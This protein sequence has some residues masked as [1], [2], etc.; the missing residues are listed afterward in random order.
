[1]Q[2][3]HKRATRIAAGARCLLCR[4][5]KSVGRCVPAHFP[6]HRGMGAGHAGWGDDE[7]VPLCG[8]LNECHDLVDG[9]V[10]TSLE[11][12]EAHEQARRDVMERAPAWWASVKGER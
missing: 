3:A 4:S 9:R 1:M 11:R 8:G 5:P 12:W 6:R 7:W 2:E 10:G